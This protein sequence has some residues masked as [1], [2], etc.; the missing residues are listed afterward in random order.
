MLKAKYVLHVLASEMR[1]V[2]E[3]NLWKR[4]REESRLRKGVLISLVSETKSKRGKFVKIKFETEREINLRGKPFRDWPIWEFQLDYGRRKKLCWI[5]GESFGRKKNGLID[6]IF[7]EVLY[8]SINIY[9]Y[10]ELFEYTLVDNKFGAERFI[11]FFFFLFFFFSGK[12]SF[13]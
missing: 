1:I 2:R 13:L 12:E 3:K 10:L 11:S 6:H 7:Q 8:Q 9:T 4:K 5:L